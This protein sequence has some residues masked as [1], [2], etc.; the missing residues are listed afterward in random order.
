MLFSEMRTVLQT[1]SSLAKAVYG[2]ELVFTR[3]TIY[4]DGSGRIE[5][6][7]P[8]DQNLVKFKTLTFPNEEQMYDVLF[9]VRKQFQKKYDT[10]RQDCGVGNEGGDNATRE[11]TT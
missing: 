8:R 4:G 3:V 1:I 2:S 6:D 10:Q 5:I 7:N 11:N 9:H